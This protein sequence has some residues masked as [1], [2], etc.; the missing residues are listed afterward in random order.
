[1]TSEP[2][3]ARVLD[4]D[5]KIL[6]GKRVSAEQLADLTEELRRLREREFP[7]PKLVVVL[8]G[9]D[10]ASQVY[11]GKKAKTAQQIGMAS[12]VLTY[13][14]NTTQVD[15]LA[16]IDRLNADASVHGILIQLPLPRHIDSL[17]VINAIDPRKD[18]D[19]LHPLNLGRLL[20]GDTATCPPCTPA[21][22]M[23]LLRAYDVPLAGKHAVILG[24]SNIV[25]KP[26]GL[27]LLREDATVSYCHSRTPHLPAWI[28]RADI[29]VAA[30]GV[31]GLVK[32]A[33]L[34]PGAVVVDVGINRVDGKLAGDV[35][36]AS[37]A[38]RASLIT[39]VPG[40]V[41]PMTIA[42]LMANTLACY[43]RALD[44]SL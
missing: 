9:D 17:A 31:P 13:P 38:G 10:P 21:G 43:R 11:V 5:T 29:L 1:M 39:P 42:T 12:D 32:G 6:D 22:V 20:T 15:L 34:K 35:D 16:V 41:G 27:L 8:V 18:V 2:T 44:V 23:T 3:T 26:M 7:V 36:F 28:A 25:G 40:G 14:A 24:R 19:G 37:A 4:T 33:D 30:V